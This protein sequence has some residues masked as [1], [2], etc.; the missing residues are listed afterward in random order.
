MRYFCVLMNATNVA[1]VV[2]DRLEKYGF[3]AHRCVIAVDEVEAVAKAISSVR[4]E[5][6]E[7]TLL[8]FVGDEIHVG[9]EQVDELEAFD[10]DVAVGFAF[11]PD[12]DN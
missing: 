7:K 6:E 3:Y 4:A 12:Q 11:Y 8:C 10:A 9:V 2:G 1:L 5:I